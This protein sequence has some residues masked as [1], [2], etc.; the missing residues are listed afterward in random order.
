MK[1]ELTVVGIRNYCR[2]EEGYSDL[3]ARVP[4]GSEVVL[5]TNRPGEQFPGSI[6]V[7]DQEMQM[8][9]CISKTDRRLIQME[10]PEDGGVLYARVKSHV[11]EDKC[12]M[13]EAE[14]TRGIK[15]PYL[16]VIE[17]E[18][19]EIVFRTTDYDLQ[20]ER[21]ADLILAQLRRMRECD[22]TDAQMA[23]LTKVLEEY[24]GICCNS[25]DGESSFKR[26]DIRMYLK[27]FSER[28]PQLYPFYMNIHEQQKDLGHRNNEMKVKVYRRQYQQIY[29][30]ATTKGK[31]GKSQLEEYVDRLRFRNGGDLPEDAVREELAR[32]SGKL[33]VELMNRYVSCVDSKEEFATSL[34]SLNYRLRSIYVLY[35]RRIMHHHLQE[36]LS[37]SSEKVVEELCPIFYEDKKQARAFLQRIKGMKNTDITR[38]VNQLVEQGVISDLSCHRDLW[39]VL[40]NN[41]LYTPT[42]TN[43]NAQVAKKAIR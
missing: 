21:L 33:S 35:T 12:V 40:H 2:D 5:R 11:P 38:L 8:I 22:V 3:F 4:I 29:D 14:N 34:Y 30:S 19:D 24:S 17:P 37:G 9:G 20:M 15:E 16:R 43:W 1:V 26:A 27:M 10:M 31:N 18:E 42:E 28:Y 32:L 39:K 36:L 6:S 7:Y 13:I 41:G 23:S 25:L